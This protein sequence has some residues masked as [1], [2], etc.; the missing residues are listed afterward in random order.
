MSLWDVVLRE[1]QDPDA[2][3]TRSI[4]RIVTI[5]VEADTVGEAGT[6]ALASDE[7]PTTT[8]SWVIRTAREVMPPTGTGDQF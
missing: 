2:Y 3:D 1:E 8:T 7:L 4:S 5:T 6:A